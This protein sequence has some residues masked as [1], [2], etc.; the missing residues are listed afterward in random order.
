VALLYK[1]LAPA[2]KDLAALMVLLVLVGVPIAMLNQVHQAAALLL[3]S[4][5]GYLKALAPDQI[6]AQVMFFLELHKQGSLV[7]AIFW[8]L[9]LFPLGLLV[10]R[11]GFYPRILGVL[12][13]IGGFG[14]LMVPI[15]RLLLPGDPALA[16]ARFAAHGAELSWMLWLLIKGVDVE[17]WRQRALEAP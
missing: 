4:G 15:Q 2:G 5:A 16:N 14:W 13:M 6:Q 7:G 1:L 8:G 12:L 11:S 10:F 17:R 3:L 9:W